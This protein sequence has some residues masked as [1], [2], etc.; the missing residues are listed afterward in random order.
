[1]RDER[2]PVV[3]W[4][5]AA[6]GRREVLLP[7]P[8]SF[9]AD[10]FNCAEIG[11]TLPHADAALRLLL[12]R[13]PAG[14]RL[15]SDSGSSSSGGGESGSDSD[16]YSAAAAAVRAQ[17][18]GVQ[19]ALP[20]VYALLHQ[21][22]VLTR[23]GQHALHARWAAAAWGVCPRALCGGMALLPRGASVAPRR[24]TLELYC[25]RCRGLFAPGALGTPGAWRRGTRS[26][27]AQLD[28]AAFG[29][30]AAHAMLLAYADGLPAYVPPGRYV[31]RIYGFR[32]RGASVAPPADDSLPASYC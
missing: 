19:A 8:R 12:L 20:H 11:A 26:A 22:Y 16:A 14:L 17:P 10:E 4:L 7:V 30:T 6:P 21:R 2:L 24:G 29:P 5:L 23:P 32:V 25:P 15:A 3:E 27:V 13:P 1:M 18:A 31:P 28:G 9:L